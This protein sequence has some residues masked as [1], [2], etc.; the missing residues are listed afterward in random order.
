M[1]PDG[2]SSVTAQDL[3]ERLAR[4]LN[5]DN[6]AAFFALYNEDAILLPPEQKTIMGRYVIEKF[7]RAASDLM[8]DVVVHTEEV[9]R[10]GDKILAERGTM[11]FETRSQPAETKS[12]K[13]L[14]LWDRTGAGWKI[15]TDIWNLDA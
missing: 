9:R 10:L 5:Q 1:A 13:Y 2:T 11:T 14:I 15:G 4:H 7:W 6:M 3:S 8:R 12:G